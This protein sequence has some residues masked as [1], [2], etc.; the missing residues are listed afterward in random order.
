MASDGPSLHRRLTDAIL[1]GAEAQEDSRRAMTTCADVIAHARATVRE[2]QEAR[3]AR[4]RA[5]TFAIGQVD[6]K[7][8][9]RSG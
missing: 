9:G 3:R 1:H 6:A 7:N 2:S 5:S 8:R 4:R